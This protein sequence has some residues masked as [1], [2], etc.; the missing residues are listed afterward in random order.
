MDL[1]QPFQPGL[2]GS[3]ATRSLGTL[4]PKL[5]LS[6]WLRIE[7][8]T[9]LQ[10]GPDFQELI[11]REKCQ[12]FRGAAGGQGD[13]QLELLP[14]SRKLWAPAPPRAH[15]RRT[16]GPPKCTRAVGGPTGTGLWP[17]EEPGGQGEAQA[18][19]APHSPRPRPGGWAS[20]LQRAGCDP[21]G[22]LAHVSL[23]WPRRGRSWLDGAH[24]LQ[25]PTS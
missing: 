1:P 3:C 18:R 7:G 25:G 19:G 23:A 10:L 8:G 9:S 20:S 5:Q 16:P 13:D 17:H 11:S 4:T 15:P 14:L 22:S 12:E 24:A 6:P 2:L 21:T